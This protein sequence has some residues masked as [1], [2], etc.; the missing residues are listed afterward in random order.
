MVARG[1]LPWSSHAS[2]LSRFTL[3][4]MLLI[5]PSAL[6]RTPPP[7]SAGQPRC[8]RA[9]GCPAP[10]C[11]GGRRARRLLAWSGSPHRNALASQSASRYCAA[12][13]CFPEIG[14]AHV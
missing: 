4:L 12:V 9:S 7:R 3:L 5:V 1:D 13:P 6:A 8:P 11:L 14:R 2:T 10:A